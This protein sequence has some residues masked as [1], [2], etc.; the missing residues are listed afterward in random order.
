M[1]SIPKSFYCALLLFVGALS[2][3][4]PSPETSSGIPIDSKW[5]AEVYDYARQNIKHPSWGIAHSERNYQLTLEI[6][7]REALA[8][9]ADALFAA[10]FLHDLGAI[11]AFEKPG[12]DHAVRSAELAEPLLKAWGFPMEKWP[13]AQEMILS[14]M[15]YAQLPPTKSALAFRD[16]DTLDFLGALGAARILAAT[17]DSGPFHSLELSSPISVIRKFRADLPNTLSLPASRAMSRTRLEALDSF[18]RSAEKDA[19]NGRAY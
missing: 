15:F 8:V 16:A 14:H 6:A 7:K 3:A 9:D 1:T 4:E 2:F 17:L 19:L 12:V 5:K 18:L 13:K 10:A 11:A